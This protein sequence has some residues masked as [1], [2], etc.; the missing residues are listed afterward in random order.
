MDAM[1]PPRLL[2]VGILCWGLLGGCASE[3]YV[4]DNVTDGDTFYLAPTAYASNDAALQSWVTYSL[5]RS[6][7]QLEIGGPNPARASSFGCELEARQHLVDAWRVQR[8]KHPDAA[9]LY[10]DGLE[11]VAAADF[12]PEYVA[13][14]F[15]RRHWQLPTDL[16]SDGFAAWRRH[17]LPRHRPQTRIIGS[18]GYAQREDP[19]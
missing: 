8:G 9:D 10:L 13:R 12:L 19:Q 6:A 16:D 7:C 4:R 3:V 15:G 17:E 18:W 14:Y 5:M 1:R 2:S 11:R